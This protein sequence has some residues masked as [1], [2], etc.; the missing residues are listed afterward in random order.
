MNFEDAFRRVIGHEGGYSNDPRDA[1][2]ETMYG[3]SKR[4]YPDEDIKGMTLDRAK[5]IYR[6]DY[7]GPT[8][9]DLLPGPLN[10]AVFDLAVNA[11]PRAAVKALQLAVG[12]T[13]DGVIGRDT[14]A[15]VELCD[16]YR[17]A[18]FVHAAGLERRTNAA[19]WPTH[20]RGWARRVVRNLLEM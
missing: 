12:V 5:A 8:G 13:A 20:G 1:G 17:A 4:A 11:G 2:G 19:S 14:R 15:A 6:R 16:P 18:V 3:I 10:F 9:C 7:W